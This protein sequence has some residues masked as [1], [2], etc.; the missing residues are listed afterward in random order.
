MTLPPCQ[1][2]LDVNVIVDS[3]AVTALKVRV[4]G[5]DFAVFELIAKVVG[6]K[7]VCTIVA[8]A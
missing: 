3:S 2:P 5:V 8:A 1:C 4:R 7:T 6:V